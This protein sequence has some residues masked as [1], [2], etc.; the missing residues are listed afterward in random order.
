MFVRLRP[1]RRI[2]FR[3]VSA[4][5]GQGR[6][7][8]CGGDPVGAQRSIVHA[9]TLRSNPSPAVTHVGAVS[10]LNT[11][12]LIE[13]LE[14]DPRI[15]LVYD[16][17]ARLPARL[18]AGEV[19]A[20]LVPVVDLLQSGERWSLLSDACIAADGETMTVR[21]FSRI[22][23]D[24]IRT[25]FVDGHSHTSVALAR[26]IWLQVHGQALSVEPLA[27][28]DDLDGCDAVLL[29]GD[30]VVGADVHGFSYD[31]DLG[32]AWRA[33][34][35]LPFVFAVWA[36]ARP[37]DL[38]WLAEPLNAA[39][40]RGVRRAR[41]I[42]ERDAA[43]AGWP[44]PAAVDYLTNKLSYTLTPRARQGL[45]RFLHAAVEHDIITTDKATLARIA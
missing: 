21:V 25:L 35:G 33:W 26:L 30:K 43:A 36:T 16:V 32:G 7:A 9:M 4:G 20:A 5:P 40:D 34:T 13:G 3:L 24:R 14:D 15:R 2:H 22:A 39:R 8:E 41:D 27:D 19:D 37:A 23:P 17:P 44:V 12:P 11:R 45:D 38:S 10:Y 1:A 28:P 29:I 6:V 18:A 42:A 31:I